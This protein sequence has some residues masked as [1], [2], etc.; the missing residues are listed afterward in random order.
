MTWLQIL[1]TLAFRE[2]DFHHG[3]KTKVLMFA[4]CHYVIGLFKSWVD[5]VLPI[6]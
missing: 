1:T 3:T 5:G 6:T 2:I 4:V